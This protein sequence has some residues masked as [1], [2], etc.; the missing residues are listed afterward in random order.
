MYFTERPYRDVSEDEVLKNGAFFGLS[1]KFFNHEKGA[2]LYQKD[3]EEA[4]Y[5]E[6]MASMR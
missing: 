4:V 3:L 2:Q 5:A 1:N 6:E